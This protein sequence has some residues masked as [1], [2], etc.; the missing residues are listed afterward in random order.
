MITHERA[1]GAT[2]PGLPAV[3]S[4]DEWDELHDALTLA[5]DALGD[6]PADVNPDYLVNCMLHQRIALRLTHGKARA[7][8]RDC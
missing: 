6:G 4:Q 8:G 5:L 1:A 3:L 2:D 7:Q